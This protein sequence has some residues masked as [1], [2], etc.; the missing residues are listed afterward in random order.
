VGVLSKRGVMKVSI[1]GSR[2][3][4]VKGEGILLDD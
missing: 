1:D 2:F 4:I 3:T